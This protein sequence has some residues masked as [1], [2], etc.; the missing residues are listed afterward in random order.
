MSFTLFNALKIFKLTRKLTIQPASVEA[1]RVYSV[2][3]NSL[4]QTHVSFTLHHNRSVVLH[5]QRVSETANVKN[6]WI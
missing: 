5:K 3:V 4:L 6:A 1:E 2:H